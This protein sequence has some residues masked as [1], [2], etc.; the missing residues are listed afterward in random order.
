VD[1]INNPQLLANF[2]L[3]CLSAGWF[4]GKSRLNGDADRDDILTITRIINGGTNGL[5][6]RRS[7]LARAKRVLGA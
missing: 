7:Y 3:A 5:A 4:W 1:L 6:D 2:D